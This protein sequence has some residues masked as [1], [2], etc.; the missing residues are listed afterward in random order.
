MT[1]SQI[2]NEAA[3]SLAVHAATRP[4]T[5]TEMLAEIRAAAE[6]A[7]RTYWASI[8]RT[9]QDAAI[10]AL[11]SALDAPTDT[12]PGVTVVDEATGTLGWWTA[13]EAEARIGRAADVTWVEDPQGR[14]LR[15]VTT[16]GT[17]RL[18]VARYV[19]P[20]DRVSP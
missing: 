9:A 14:D 2:R 12:G 5:D 11:E 1:L 6:N 17:Y 18:E 4:L 13:R 10:R 19:P 3:L 15:V 16:D 8:A 7:V 20:T